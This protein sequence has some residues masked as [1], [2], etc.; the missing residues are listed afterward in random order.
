MQSKQINNDPVFPVER[1]T[2]AKQY[3]S[4]GLTKREYFA[5]LAM[6]VLMANPNSLFKEDAIMAFA[7][8]DAMI[9]EGSRR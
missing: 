6:Q 2:I 3:G 8:A 7:M 5:G 1:A 4:T 9:E